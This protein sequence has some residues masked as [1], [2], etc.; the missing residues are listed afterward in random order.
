MLRQQLYA[1]RPSSRWRDGAKP[2][3]E[4]RRLCE[5]EL[6]EE[7]LEETRRLAVERELERLSRAQLRT[8][9]G[10]HRQLRNDEEDDAAT[11]YIVYREIIEHINNDI[12]ARRR[13]ELIVLSL[14]TRH[15][16][17]VASSCP[18]EFQMR[19]TS[20]LQVS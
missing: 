13:L 3:R 1:A 15:W 5:N 7:K 10:R 2:G 11:S 17:A 6:A 20:A 4:L 12:I 16:S 8:Q 19:A 18:S 9:P 14:V